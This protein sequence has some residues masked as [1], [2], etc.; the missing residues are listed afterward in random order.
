[1]LPGLDGRKMSKS[2]DNTI[3]LFEGGEY[4]LKNA[5]NRIVTDSSLPG[6]PKDPDASHLYSLYQAFASTEQ[7]QAFRQDL[8]AGLAWG[9][10]KNQLFELIAAELAPMRERYKTLMAAPEQV[11][12][13]LQEGAR[14]A[15][16]YAGPFIEKLRHAVGLRQASAVVV[17]ADTQDAE[18]PK[19][20]ASHRFVSFRDDD[21]TFRFR[22]YDADD[23]ELFLS[24]PF[25]D[26]KRA[27]Y[28]MRSLQQGLREEWVV[29]DDD[30]ATIVFEEIVVCRL[31]RERIAAVQQCL[32]PVE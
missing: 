10:A 2:Y 7:A 24:E 25:M 11:E 19:S 22:L 5:I 8:L 3:P 30:T 20:K 1:T 26:P 9:D 4:A 28:V 32:Q 6:E 15:R 16:A 12:E 29:E 23:E 27:G 31:P 17:A 13:I 14:K 18:A 21:G